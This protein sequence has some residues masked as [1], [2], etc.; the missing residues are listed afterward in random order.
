MKLMVWFAVPFIGVDSP[1]FERFEGKYVY[2]QRGIMNEGTLDP[3]YP[4][5][6]EFIIG[7]YK[8]FLTEY[9]IDGFKFDFIDSFGGWGDEPKYDPEKM[10]C[11]TVSG[12][13]NLLMTEI[14]EELGKIKPDLLYEYR[15]NYVGP[16]INRFGNMLRVGDCAYESHSNRVGT[17][18]LRLLNYP[19]AVHSDMLYWAK[20]ESLKLCAR[21]LLNI[22]FSVPQI[23][24]H[25]DRITEEQKKAL[26]HYISFWREHRDILLNGK[27]Y[28][29]DP[30]AV[31]SKAYSEKDGKAVSVNYEDPT[32]QGDW[33]SLVA[34]NCTGKT[35]LYLDGFAGK[36]YKVVNCMGEEIGS[37]T[38]AEISKIS[39]PRGGMIFVD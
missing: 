10:D 12:A 31:Y 23:S 33:D 37:G 24:V 29:C 36:S 39:V 30:C 8:R 20:G 27:L 14:V 34:V 28:A 11:E 6:R 32:V 7:N 9:G 25:L 2:V 19:V 5:V 3:R 21:Q 17:V 22:L 1:L 13:V 15:Q 16:A 4:E 35:Y 26:S 18:D 38:L